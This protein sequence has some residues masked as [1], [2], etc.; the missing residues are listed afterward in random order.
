MTKTYNIAVLK[1]DGIGPEVTDATIKILQ[2]IQEIS[3]FKFNLLCGEAGYH[4]IA[5]YGTNLPK[6]TLELIKQTN[7]CLKGPMTTPEEPG[8][9]LSVAVTLRKI[10]NLYA[11]VRPCRSFPNVESL[12]SCRQTRLAPRFPRSTRT[13]EAKKSSPICLWPMRSSPHWRSG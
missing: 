1:G 6:E 9:P 13:G 4:C 11:N 5:K 7:A 12:K 2:V 3:S 8:A 10:F